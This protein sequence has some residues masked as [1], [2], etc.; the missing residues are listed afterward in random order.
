MEALQAT[1]VRLS[2]LA[3][4]ARPRRE[5]VQRLR[6]R[7]ALAM[8]RARTDGAFRAR[9]TKAFDEFCDALGAGACKLADLAARLHDARRSRGVGDPSPA[10]V[11]AFR[12]PA[13]TFDGLS[14]VRLYRALK[15]LQL[16]AAAPA[17][18]HLAAALAAQRFVMQDKL[19]AFV[20][21]LGAKVGV[22]PE[23]A[24]VRRCG[25]FLHRQ[26]RLENLIEA[27]IS[28]AAA[29]PATG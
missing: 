2:E 16:P 23:P 5:A 7:L 25:A 22:V 27:H 19:D 26:M 14:G 24:A 4:Y 29:A 9:L 15:A 13:A 28:L 12:L 17:D 11:A 10:A 6:E 20:D 1:I 8:A 3:R 18:A 21:A